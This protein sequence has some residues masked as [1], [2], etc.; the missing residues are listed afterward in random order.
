MIVIN[1][2]QKNELGFSFIPFPVC[3]DKNITE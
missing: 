3:K 1:K 2:S